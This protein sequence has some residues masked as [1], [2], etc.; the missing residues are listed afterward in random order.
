M[1]SFYFHYVGILSMAN[2]GSNTNSSQ[3]FICTVKTHWL[4]KKHVV[5][6]KVVEGMKVV[7]KMEEFG[8]QSGK[9]IEEIEIADCGELEISS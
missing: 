3:F 6:G 1:H 8:S 9:T 5:F 4:D 2:R 7:R